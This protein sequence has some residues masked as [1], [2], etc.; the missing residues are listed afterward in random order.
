[1]FTGI[2]QD[3]GTVLLKKQSDKT[4]TLKIKTLLTNIN[5]GDS[6]SVNGVCLTVTKVEPV[7]Q[8]IVFETDLSHET[9]SRTS[10]SLLGTGNRVNLE[11][12]VTANTLLGGHIVTGHVQTTIRI[13]SIKNEVWTFSCPAEIS[14]YIVAKGSVTIDGIS[15]TV[16]EQRDNRFTVAIIP[17]T[18]KNTTLQFK[19]PGDILNI[20]PDIFSKYIE[21]HLKEKDR[22]KSIS[23][24][25]LKKYGW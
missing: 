23:V 20:E 6:I 4:V 12:S 8:Q 15:L 7:Y 18:F 3:I 10:M 22:E 16:V 5:K 24:E 1:M 21:K 13:L 14:K 19:K 17:H 9:H 25:D 2:I 11:S